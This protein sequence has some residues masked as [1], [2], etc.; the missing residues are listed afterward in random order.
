MA[1]L[2]A[3]VYVGEAKYIKQPQLWAKP[4]KVDL[5][6]AVPRSLFGQV[7]TYWQEADQGLLHKG[8][9]LLVRHIKALYSD[10]GTKRGPKGR[11]Y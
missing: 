8:P 5:L 3:L 10:E 6:R 2:R 11:D 9:L 7:Y 4:G 1:Y